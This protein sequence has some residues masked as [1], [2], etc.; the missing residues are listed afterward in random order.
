[1]NQYAVDPFAAP[2]GWLGRLA[3]WWMAHANRPLAAWAVAGLALQP[4]DRVLDIGSGPGVGLALAARRLARGLAVGVDPSA[5]MH[6]QASR[7]N[8]KGLREGRA[9]LVQAR[10]SALPFADGGFH[11]VMSVNT[12]QLWPE[13]VSDLEEVRRV[14]VPGARLVVVMHGHGARH[15]EQVQEQQ[16]RCLEWIEQARLA[17]LQALVRRVR[18]LPALRVIAE[19]G[20]GDG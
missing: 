15:D 20:A 13:P 10:A 3:G 14:M 6:R 8:R 2:R 16:R 9:G 5:D 19:R 11:K 7:R 18:G 12:I 1:M 17:P 4:V